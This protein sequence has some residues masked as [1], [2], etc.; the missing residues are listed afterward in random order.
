MARVVT[1]IKYLLPAI[2]ALGLGLVFVAS[3][4]QRFSIDCTQGGQC[5]WIVGGIASVRNLHF[6]VADVREVRLVDGFGKYGH[7]SDIALVFADGR[8]RS[9]GRADRDSVLPTFESARAFFRTGGTP[10]FSY[11]KRGNHGLQ[12]AGLG[13]LIAALVLG[14]IGARKRI[15]DWVDIPGARVEP[16]LAERA[17]RRRRWWMIG[18]GVVAVA[19]FMG[20]MALYQT[21]TQGKLELTCQTRCRLDGIECMPGAVLSTSLDPGDYIVE[22]WQGAGVALWKPVPFHIAV[23]ETTA[24]TC[25]P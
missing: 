15:L 8:Q 13:A 20:A 21:W 2:A 5:D 11:S 14:V 9:F 17:A 24:V 7:D 4:A 16:T 22:V 6:N 25:A 23:G 10:Q 19:A 12:V 3:G 18:G 1:R